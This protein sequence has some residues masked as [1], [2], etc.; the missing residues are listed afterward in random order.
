VKGVGVANFKRWGPAQNDLVAGA[1]R[2][3]RSLVVCVGEMLLRG[4]QKK[5]RQLEVD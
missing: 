5:K 1:K 4:E 2:E 3:E